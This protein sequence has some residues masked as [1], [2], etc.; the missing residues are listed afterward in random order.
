MS[1]SSKEINYK[2]TGIDCPSCASGIEQALQEQRGLKTAVVDFAGGVIRFNPVYEETVRSVLKEIEPQARIRASSD[3]DDSEKKLIFGFFPLK[4]FLSLVLF[5]S[6]LIVMSFKPGF[7]WL[8]WVLFLSS[9]ALAGQPVIFGAVRNILKGRIIDELFLMTVATI[10]AFVIGELPEAAAVMLFYTIGETLQT[11]AVSRSRDAIQGAMA[12]RVSIVRLVSDSEVNEVRPESVSIGSILEILP[13][14]MLALDGMVIEGESWMDTSA[15]TGESTLR[16]ASPGDA[17]SAGFINDDGRIRV[18]T[19]KQYG[20]SAIARVK[21]LLVEASSRKS[22]TEMILSRFAAIYTPVIV[23]LAAL[24]IFVMP[25][26]FGWSFSDSIYSAMIL[27]VI[28]CPCALVVSVPLAYF[29]GIGRA[30]REKTL[31]RGGDVLDALSRIR[32]VVLDKTGTL[33]NGDF[34]LQSIVPAEGWDADVLLET[35]ALV[36]SLSNHPIA[37]SVCEAWNGVSEADAVESFREI[38]GRGIVAELGGRK[39]LAG[40]SPLLLQEGIT[41]LEP[42]DSGSVVHLAVDDEYAGYILLSDSLKIDSIQA[43]AELKKIGVHRQVMLTGD[44]KDRGE[45]AA[46]ALGIREVKCE[47]LPEGKM[48]ALEQIIAETSPEEGVAFVGDGLNDAPVILRAD[49]GMA[50]GRSGTDL[51]IESADVVFMDDNPLRIPRLINLARFTK[52]I[53]IGNIVFALVIKL[54]FMVLGVF[55]GLPMWAAVIGD[56][57]VSILAVLNSLRILYGNKTNIVINKGI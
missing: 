13:G 27:L 1:D 10:G 6:G 36:L 25:L 20:D 39:I 43:V 54:G 48:S 33:T 50:M 14:D 23:A 18:Q 46:H 45:Q 24:L 5:G 19:T 8:E 40:S 42:E 53:V 30:S 49:V 57:G 26:F 15:L 44:R 21:K 35:A 17:V 7:S 29:A 32:T 41:A 11:R 28:S 55:S 2:L 9:Y 16:R 34:K 52:R 51:A 4:L 37:R 56:V 3:A 12:L 38:K 47:L 31:L 22:K